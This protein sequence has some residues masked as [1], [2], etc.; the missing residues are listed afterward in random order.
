MAVGAS[1]GGL[2]GAVFDLDKS[3][4]DMTFL[5]DVSKTL[6]AGKVAVL[7]E[8]EESWTTPVDTRLHSLGGIVFRRLRGEIVADQVVRESGA[9]E[10]DLKALD[11]DLK[12]ATAENRSAIQ[13][14]I[15]RVKKQLKAT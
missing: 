15:E 12:Q 7:A 11:E 1:L 3:G 4:V 13:K 6:T 9:L 5:D 2:A 14:D 8:V 10:A